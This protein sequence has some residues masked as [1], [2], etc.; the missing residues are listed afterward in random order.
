MLL[1]RYIMINFINQKIF[2]IKIYIE[3]QKPRKD[4]SNLRKYINLSKKIYF[5]IY[6]YILI[7]INVY[8]LYSVP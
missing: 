4:I 1:L 7:Y 5:H 8:I 2:T 3:L 6:T